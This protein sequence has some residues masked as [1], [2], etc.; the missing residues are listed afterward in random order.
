MGNTTSE[1]RANEANQ[2]SR[3]RLAHRLR[4]FQSG[5][6]QRS[7][8]SI[9][10]HSTSLSNM[11]PEEDCGVLSCSKLKADFIE[12]RP[13]VEA[14][15][16]ASASHQRAMLACESATSFLCFCTLHVPKVSSP[17]SL[18]DEWQKEQANMPSG[19]KS[20]GDHV[21]AKRAD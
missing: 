18:E 3:H 4:A 20:V 12:L 8:K 19:S 6:C 1:S 13:S 14:G 10:T 5:T 17:H 7:E 21:R 16:D 2:P 15:H 11:I 9:P